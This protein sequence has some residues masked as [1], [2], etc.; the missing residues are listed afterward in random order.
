MTGM[1]QRG[2]EV[3]AKTLRGEANRLRWEVDL[4]LGVWPNEAPPS[5]W[6]F[7]DVVCALEPMAETLAIVRRALVTVDDLLPEQHRA[8]VLGGDVRGQFAQ[9]LDYFF[10]YHETPR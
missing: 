2:A 5:P 4:A 8:R 7:N 6:H 1:R 10:G 3:R 9:R